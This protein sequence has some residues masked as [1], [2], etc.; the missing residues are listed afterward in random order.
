MNAAIQ[1]LAGFFE[2]L[3]RISWQASVLVGIILAI[4]WLLRKR[5][6]PAWRHGLW[7]LLLARLVLP[8]SFES[9][10][11]IFNWIRFERTPTS[12]WHWESAAALPAPGGADQLR[13]LLDATEVLDR[14]ST[15]L[16]SSH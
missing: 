16:N 1:L 5:L 8:G 15:R 10:W 6:S 9:G 7:F 4:Q 12:R 11:S 2:A 13:P 14:K 3:V